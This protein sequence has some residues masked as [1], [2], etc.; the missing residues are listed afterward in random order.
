MKLYIEISFFDAMMDLPRGA[1]KKAREFLKKFQADPKSSGIHLEKISQWNQ[2]ELRSARVDQSYR[3]VVYQAPR[4][5]V[6]RL[7]WVGNHDDAYDWP[8]GKQFAWNE[9]V[10]SFQVFE[11]QTEAEAVAPANPVEGVEGIVSKDIFVELDDEQLLRLGVPAAALPRVR[12][13]TRDEDFWQL[14]K[15]LPQDAF[16]YLF[17]FMEGA[18]FE[19]LTAEIEAGKSEVVEPTQAVDSPN[20]MRYS[21]LVVDDA[22]LERI[23]GEGQEKWQVFLHPSQHQLAYRSYPGSMKV[24]G[25]AGTGKTVAALHRAKYLSEQPNFDL[26]HPLLFTTY[27]KRLTSALQKQAQSLGIDSQRVHIHNIHKLGYEVAIQLGIIQEDTNFLDFTQAE[28]ELELWTEV[29]DFHASEFFAE[30]LQEEY[31]A[32]VLDQDLQSEAD[33]LKASRLGRTFRVSRKQRKELWRLF[34][35]FQQLREK[36]HFAHFGDVLNR[37]TRH[38]TNYPDQRPYRHVVCDELQDLSN[39]ELRFL[40]CLVPEGPNDLFLVGDPLQKIYARKLSFTSLGINVRGRR[41]RRLKLNYRTTKEIKRAAVATIQSIPLSDFDDGEESKD[42]YLSLM[43][44]A[45]PV[46]HVYPNREAELVAVLEFLRQIE[47]DGRLSW[48]EVVLAAPRQSQVKDLKSMLHEARLPYF[49]LLDVK[50]EA[51]G[52]HLSTFH[53][54]KGLEFR[55]V[56]LT[57]IDQQSVPSRPRSFN[58]W[59]K[60]EQHYHDQRERSLLYVAMSRA[61]SQLTLTGSGERSSLVGF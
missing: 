11:A 29:L 49:D 4:E 5:E 32:L 31:H 9:Q 33:Y 20:A 7:L 61:I 15:A 34:E 35:T 17:Y 48:A 42:G 44:G 28:K 60:A 51:D 25:A 14:E 57:H 12:R 18:S 2:P 27:T 56:V 3:A 58:G 22:D 59:S 13:I 1:Q 38:L 53:T 23:L 40:R 52:I 30:Q 21:R 16:E 41:S 10:Q 26:E 36:Y 19:S 50:G 37:V 24:T 39:L 6:F 45:S 47:A 8:M 46:Y 43:H 54:L 55:C